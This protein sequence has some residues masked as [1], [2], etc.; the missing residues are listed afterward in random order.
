[1]GTTFLDRREG[2]SYIYIYRYTIGIIYEVS[3]GRTQSATEALQAHFIS[4]GWQS[5]RGENG[6]SKEKFSR[7]NAKMVSK[8]VS[9]MIINKIIS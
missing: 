5:K 2:T 1:M 4:G 9:K 6:N 7:R 3:T 8:Q